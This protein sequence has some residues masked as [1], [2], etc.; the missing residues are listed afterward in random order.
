MVQPTALCCLPPAV[1]LLPFKPSSHHR[2]DISANVKVA[3]DGNAERI[4]GA[5]KIFEDDVDHVFV[6]YLHVTK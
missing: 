1:C 3:F 5:Y 4:T 6:K 2:F